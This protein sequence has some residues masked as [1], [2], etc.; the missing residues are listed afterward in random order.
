MKK[1][2]IKI[3]FLSTIIGASVFSLTS[4]NQQIW[5]FNY[6]YDYAIIQLGNGKV[7]E[8][9]IKYWTDYEDGEQ[10]QITME[11]GTVYLTSSF[12]CTLIYYGR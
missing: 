7:V 3:A 10:L 4:C 8:G 5:D 9:K 12:N 11:D 6:K 2:L 1:F